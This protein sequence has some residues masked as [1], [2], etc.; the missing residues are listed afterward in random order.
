M[1]PKIST[2]EA[3]FL[4]MAGV[5][6]DLINW[7]PVVNWIVAIFMFPIT[8]LYFRMKGVRGQYALIG[9][10]MELIP[11]LSVLPAYTIAMV[12]TIYLDR[13]PELMTK[14]QQGVLKEKMGQT[15]ASKEIKSAAPVA[16]KSK[17]ITEVIKKV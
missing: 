16:Q 5:V 15:S 13:H 6:A 10:I 1:G 12:A 2:T 4:I 8:Q 17:R 3:M 7:I 9:N 14:G 11:G